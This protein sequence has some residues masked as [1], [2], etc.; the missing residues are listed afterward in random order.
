MQIYKVFDTATP[1]V[2]PEFVGS[3]SDAHTRAKF[4]PHRPD[5]RIELADVPTDKAA[6][7]LYMNGQADIVEFLVQRTWSLTDRGGLK[8]IANGD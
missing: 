8:E 6:L 7:L 2:R 5:A 4:I 1:E 3:L